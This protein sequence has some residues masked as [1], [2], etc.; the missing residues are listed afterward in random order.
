MKGKFLPLL[1]ISLFALMFA[2]CGANKEVAKNDSSK[3]APAEVHKSGIVSELLEQ[4]RQS[5]VLAL[6]KQEQNSTVEAINNYE[7][8]LRIIDNLSYYPNI[9]ENEAYVELENSII[10]DYRK[11]VDSLPELPENVSFAVLE[12]WM[13]KKLPEIKPSKE[14]AQKAASTKV[15]IASDFPLEVNSYVE[16]YIEYFTNQPRGRKFLTRCLELSGKYMPMIMKV[17]EEEKIPKELAYLSFIESGLNPTIRSRANAIGMWQFIRATGES[18]GLR[19][20]FYFD[21][22]RDPEKATRAAARYM[23]DLYSSLGHWYLVLCGYNAGEGR[24]NKAIKRSGTNDFWQLREY[25]P[26]ETRAYVPQ[27]IAVT[28]IALDPVKYGFTNI[29]KKKPLEYEAYNVKDAID[30]G[31]L[32]KCAGTSVDALRD[33]NPELIQNCTP[34]NI[35]NGYM[36]KL[37]VGSKNTFAANIV[38]IPESAKRM[39]VVHAV[40][41]GETLAKI[42][43]KYGVSKNDLADA[44]NITI[45]TRLSRGIRLKIPVKSINPSD[46]ADNSNESTAEESNEPAASEY[47]S[48]YAAVNSTVAETAAKDV[49]KEGETDNSSSDVAVNSPK[50]KSTDGDQQVSEAPIVPAGK[51]AVSYTVKSNESLLKIADLFNARVS[52]VRNWN[53][54][55][56]TETI[57][58]GQKLTMYVPEDKA[59][60]YSSL[61]NLSSSERSIT[62]TAVSKTTKSGKLWVTHK[63]R[64][65]ET[66]YS[67]A[68]KYDVDVKKLKEWNKLSSN[69]VPVNRVLKIYTAGSSNDY[70]YNDAP[71]SKKTKLF[72]YKV[73]RG[74]NLGSIADKFG[75]SIAQ[76][77]KWNN[78]KTTNIAAGKVVKIFSNEGGAAYGDN[79]SKLNANINTYKVKKNET[80][81]QIASKFK[82]S[83]ANLKKWNKLKSNKINAGQ[84][85]KIYSDASVNDVSVERGSSKVSGKLSKAKAEKESKVVKSAKET[86]AEKLRAAKE[87]KAEKAAVA[88]KAKAMPK[89]HKVAKGETLSSI[90][91]KYDIPLDKLK[92]LNKTSAKKLQVGQ[93]VVLK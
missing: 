78:I 15:N 65:K 39:Y 14:T 19:T 88:K 31:Y 71:V 33:L 87:E 12:D 73:K 74:D 32:A 61:D 6:T 75:V 3:E 77:K 35:S 36:L 82:V 7:N 47:I 24:I 21:E 53:N 76:V 55:P 25:L 2:S 17:F 89:S 30:L 92:K 68:S 42:A 29:Q 28:L 22:K 10:E 16:Q 54:I 20:N 9:E 4:A 13:G 79:V 49:E 67:I 60:F 41:K 84:A 1:V 11:Y 72:K 44:N 85:L 34:N 5:Y 50:E 86:K 66:L 80:I 18:Y 45:R 59:G 90:A 52:D 63:V 64:K 58:V 81:G 26:L 8:A 51:A 38:N 40:K 37:P 62:K 48:P 57:K 93:K 69:K 43:D 83:V 91:D 23:K 56:Y 27:F 70:A 46:F